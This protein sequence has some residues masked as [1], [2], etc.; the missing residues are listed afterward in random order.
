MD[1]NLK[2]YSG[3]SLMHGGRQTLLQ[4]MQKLAHEHSEPSSLQNSNIKSKRKCKLS[5]KKPRPP[6]NR[7]INAK[8]HKL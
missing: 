2:M 5:N 3:V 6:M 8:S 1:F 7:N 4:P